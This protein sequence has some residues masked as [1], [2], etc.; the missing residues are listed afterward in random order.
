MRRHST[1]SKSSSTEAQFLMFMMHMIAR[2]PIES[3]KGL[4]ICEP[5]L[6]STSFDDIWDDVL[7]ETESREKGESTVG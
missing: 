5:V 1:M 6:A 2:S 7:P 3:S 4:T